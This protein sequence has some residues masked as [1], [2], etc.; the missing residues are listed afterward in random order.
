MNVP[1]VISLALHILFLLLLTFG[2]RNPFSYKID[3]KG[4]AVFEFKEI[5][6]KS[7]APVLSQTES[8]VSKLPVQNSE[9]KIPEKK[10]KKTSENTARDNKKEE[11]KQEEVNIDNDQKKNSPPKK[12]QKKENEHRKKRTDKAVV[13]L[14]K[15]QKAPKK[16]NPKAKKKSFDSILNDAI[17]TGE[18]E[19]EG[20]KA[21]ANGAVLTATQ[22]DLIRQTIRKCW[23]FPAGLKNAEELSVDIKMELAEDG[24]VKKAEIVDEK[25][26][27]SDPDFKIAAENAKRAVLDPEC[28]PLP[29][30][31]EKYKEWKDL[32]LTF[33]PKDMF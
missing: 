19:N 32:E 9:E 22:I 18:S 24:T 25:R 11:K 30:P 26:M 12:P 15:D 33:N 28:S 8:H 6:P 5:G 4:Y 20:I 29:L 7:M 27:N 31:K 14:K 1:L 23:H 3:D 17:A 2:V 21:E 13:D 10:P 16:N